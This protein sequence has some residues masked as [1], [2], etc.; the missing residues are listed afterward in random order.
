MKG[1]G[2]CRRYASKEAD[3][4]AKVK[5]EQQ[6]AN[7][8]AAKAAAKQGKSVDPVRTLTDEQLRMVH[9]TVKTRLSTQFANMREMF[10]SMDTDRSGTISPEVQRS[11]SFHR[12]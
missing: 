7:E 11:D 1:A 12:R 4:I 3:A 2:A 9:K 6:K 8:V 5:A 10:K